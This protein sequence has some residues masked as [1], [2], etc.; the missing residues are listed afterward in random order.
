[1]DGPLFPTRW[2]HDKPPTIEAFVDTF[3]DDYACAEYLAKKRWPHGFVCPHC[4]SR[5]GWR[6]ESRPW[7]FECGGKKADEDGVLVPCRKQTSVIAGTVMQGTHLPLRKWFL[8][9]YLMATHSNSISALQLQPKLGVTYK[10]AWLLLHK[11]R[12]A[13]VDP[14]RTPL[15]GNIDVDESA[16]PYER[17]EDSGKRGGGSSTVNQMWIAGAV[18]YKDRH[19]VGRIRLARIADRSAAS[20]VPFV[21]A[22][23]EPGSR[24]RTDSLSAYGKVPGRWLNQV[25]LKKLNLEA[26]VVFK[27]IHMVFGNLKRW[28]LGTFHGFRE[29]HL[30]AYLNE[31]VFRWNRR[32]HFRGTMDTML[33]IGRKVGNVTYRGIVGNTTAWKYDHIDAILRMCNPNKARI[34][35]DLSKYYRVHKVIVMERL[36]WWV[37]RLEEED[38]YAFAD[39]EWS[40]D[41]VPELNPRRKYRRPKPRRPILTPRRPGEERPTGR[42]YAKP[43][44]L[45]PRIVALPPARGTTIALAAE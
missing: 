23:T 44:P 36:A 43:D 10:T 25:N 4:G 41:G 7:V 35:R 33:G 24:L 40:F 26:H 28:A 21:I 8:A 39:Y 37:R 17:K 38:P 6:L 13:M 9:A 19:A 22:N 31:F 14:D 32:R 30:D 42:R 20:L 18:E 2:K 12:K 34:V 1:M 16:I 3:R 45:V 5:K 11:L 15:S 27:W 29:K